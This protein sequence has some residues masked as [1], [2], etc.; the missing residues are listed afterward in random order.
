MLSGDKSENVWD[1][2]LLNATPL[3]LGVENVDGVMTVLAKCNTAIHTEK[4]QT[5]TTYFDKLGV[6]I[7]VCEGGKIMTKA[8]KLLG[9]FELT[10]IPPTPRG[11]SQT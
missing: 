4:T 5:F 8:N 10:G 2:L 7:H 6:L 1:L 11:I 3:S 9:K